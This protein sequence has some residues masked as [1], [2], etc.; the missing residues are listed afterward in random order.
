MVRGH[1]WG[2]GVRD[3]P[4]SHEG[5]DSLEAS[6]KLQKASQVWGSLN[7]EMSVYQCHEVQSL[8]P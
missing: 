3:P 1:L 7:L 4:I 6:K 8:V 5:T 2:L